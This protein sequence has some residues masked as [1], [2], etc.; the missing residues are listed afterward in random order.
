[1]LEHPLHDRISPLPVQGNFLQVLSDVFEDFTFQLVIPFLFAFASFFLNLLDQFITY[2]REV[3]DKVEWILNLM[4]NTG[5]EL[6]KRSHFLR[7]DQLGLGCLKFINS[8]VQLGRSVSDLIFQDFILFF[9][10]F[11]SHLNNNVN[12]GTEDYCK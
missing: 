6:S 12:G 11:R 7:L 9:E 2:L 4:R 5:R 3:V 8:L 10:H 1:M